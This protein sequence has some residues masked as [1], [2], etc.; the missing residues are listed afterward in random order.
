M[1][2]HAPSELQLVTDPILVIKRTFGPQMSAEA[3]M[4]QIVSDLV[5]QRSLPFSVDHVDEWW[6]ISSAKD[7]LLGPDGS[8][9]LQNF[10]RIVHF[11]EAGRE[12]CHSEIMLTAF[13]DAVIT[14]GANDELTWISGDQG[15]FTVPATILD[16]M[17]CNPGRTVAF[18]SGGEQSTH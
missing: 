2:S 16:L 18:V 10:K 5:I 11:P 8:V 4:T 3:M 14:R 6:L 7:W 12:A 13:A 1:R 17:R 15:L 9:S